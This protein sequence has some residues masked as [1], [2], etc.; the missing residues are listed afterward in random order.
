MTWRVL[1]MV[2]AV[3]TTTSGIATDAQ[4]SE[5]RQQPFEQTGTASWYGPGFCGRRTADGSHFNCRAMT[6]AHNGLMLGTIVQVTDVETNRTCTVR[7]TD[8]GGFGKY[9]RII[10]LSP[11]AADC[12]GMRQRGVATVKLNTLDAQ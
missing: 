4:A 2:V 8:R 5:S 1:K 3:A 7:I 6:A 10:D 9:H 12:L 11:A